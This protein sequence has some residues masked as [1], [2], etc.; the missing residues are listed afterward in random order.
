MAKNLPEPRKR[1]KLLRREPLVFFCYGVW[2]LE[3][4]VI[5]RCEPPTRRRRCKLRLVVFQL[6]LTFDQEE[7]A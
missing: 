1:S 6:A 4:H 5:I 3:G 7:T 2:F